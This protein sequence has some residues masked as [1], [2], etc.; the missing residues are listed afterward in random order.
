MVVVDHY[1]SERHAD[2]H[3]ISLGKLKRPTCAVVA[4][5][6]RRAVVWSF[7][8]GAARVNGIQEVIQWKIECE[9]R[10]I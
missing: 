10:C 2:D 4:V 7:V 5:Q 9:V 6:A 3:S 1:L 8:G